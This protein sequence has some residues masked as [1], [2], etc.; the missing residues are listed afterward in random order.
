[1]HPQSEKSP[2]KKGRCNG[3]SG[4]TNTEIM[5]ILVTAFDKGITVH[6]QRGS[7]QG[8]GSDK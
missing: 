1:M 8:H 4:K 3:I 2:S 5:A 7:N 6:S